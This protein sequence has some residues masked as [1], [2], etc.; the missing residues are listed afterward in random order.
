MFCACGDPRGKHRPV[1][2]LES[3]E[4]LLKAVF[5]FSSLNE[6]LDSIIFLCFLTYLCELQKPDVVSSVLKKILLK[7]IIYVD[8]YKLLL[9]FIEDINKNYT[10]LVN[11]LELEI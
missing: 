7:T 11:N 5:A 3:N 10:V 9:V 6:L 2:S 4:R 1:G 8:I